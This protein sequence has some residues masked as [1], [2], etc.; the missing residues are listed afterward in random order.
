MES[1]TG[2]SMVISHSVQGKGWTKGGPVT[3]AVRLAPL[4]LYGIAG[5]AAKTIRPA[6]YG[7]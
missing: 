5:A 2:L 1:N 7:N 4:F 3:P 6:D